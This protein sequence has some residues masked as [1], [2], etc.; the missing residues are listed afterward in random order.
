MHGAGDWRGAAQKGR[1]RERQAVRA[2][3][4]EDKS[5]VEVCRG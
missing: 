1:E 4:G 3:E 5:V 2:R